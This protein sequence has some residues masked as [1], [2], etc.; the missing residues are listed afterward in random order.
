MEAMKQA[1]LTHEIPG[2]KTKEEFWNPYHWYKEMRDNHPVYYHEGQQVWNVFTYENVKRVLSDYQLFSSKSERTQIAALSQDSG[3]LD[4]TTVIFSDPPEH[5]KRRSLLSAAFTPR[6]LK[7][8]EPRINTIVNELIQDMDQMSEI[9]IV[10]SFAIPLPITIIA[11]LLGVPAVD[12]KLF[13]QWVDIIFLPFSSGNLAEQNEKKAKAALEFS[14]YLHPVIKG[15]RENPGDDIISDLIN[16]EVDEDRLTDDE[17]I[18]MTRGLLGA[19]LE[20]TSHLIANCF[21]SFLY[22]KPGIY[23]TLREDID[24]VPKAIEE[25]LRYRF[26]IMKLERTI[27]EDTD[28]FGPKMKKG[29]MIIAWTSAANLDEAVF[30]HPE[31]FD[32]FRP[33]NREHLTFGNGPHFCLGAPLARLEVEIALKAFIK[34]YPNIQSVPSFDF[35]DHLSFSAFGQSL[36]YLP[37]IAEH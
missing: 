22:D 34:H 20:T 18:K 27:K 12:R 33:N 19:G 17:I 31:Q 35:V 11:E 13:K 8:W 1:I 32:I 26:N 28:L 21:Y 4:R 16:V 15:K 25:V 7:N 6:H 3:E 9:D 2:F 24:L 37:I 36:N 14:E 29:E 10:G 30:P 5:R 23:Q